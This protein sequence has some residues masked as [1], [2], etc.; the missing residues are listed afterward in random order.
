MAVASVLNSKVSNSFAY[1]NHQRSFPDLK[2]FGIAL[3]GSVHV[4][5]QSCREPTLD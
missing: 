3:I 4:G 2:K 5:C 1:F